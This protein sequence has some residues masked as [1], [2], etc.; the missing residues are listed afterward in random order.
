MSSPIT[1]IG[2]LTVKSGLKDLKDGIDPDTYGGAPLLGVK[3]GCIIG[4]GSS[5]AYAVKNGIGMSA[6]FV[7]TGIVESI[8]QVLREAAE[9][10]AQR[11]AECTVQEEAWQGVADEQVTADP[12]AQEDA[13]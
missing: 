2:A 12:A 1:K 13:Q 3:G 7:R 11:E 4:H 6:R 9:A 5:N 10:Q 8:E